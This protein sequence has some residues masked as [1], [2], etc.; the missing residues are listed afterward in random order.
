[1]SNRSLIHSMASRVSKRWSKKSSRQNQKRSPEDFVQVPNKS[2]LT[3]RRPCSRRPTG[4][5]GQSV[6]AERDA[7]HSEAATVHTIPKVF[8]IAQQSRSPEGCRMAQDRR[9][10]FEAMI[11]RAKGDS[12][13]TT[14]EQ[15]CIQCGIRST[16]IRVFRRSLTHSRRKI[17]ASKLG[18]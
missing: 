2:D 18:R 12:A 4:D 6:C 8:G 14:L 11:A 15:N 10:W 7:S 3:N 17:R 5:V 9:A 16:A 1:M 13:V